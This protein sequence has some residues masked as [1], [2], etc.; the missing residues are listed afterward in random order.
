MSNPE[1]RK[2]W[3]YVLVGVVIGGSILAASTYVIS[4]AV[5]E[6][7]PG[8]E[9]RVAQ[10]C[11]ER[12]AQSAKAQLLYAADNNDALPEA[13]FWVDATWAYGETPNAKGEKLDPSQTNE[14]NFRCPSISA[15]REGGYGY[16][17]NSEVGKANLAG[18]DPASPLVF[19]SKLLTRNANGLPKDLL[20][21]P[22]RH[23][24][25]TANVVAMID[26]SVQMVSD[27]ALRKK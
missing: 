23:K 5:R 17:F 7:G 2:T 24:Q 14:S 3:I 26:G 21:I 27:S 6:M 25:G 4:K 16:A 10:I 15:M 13:S 8:A 22:L 12:L 18:L 9:A 11:A 19:D 1:P 20:P